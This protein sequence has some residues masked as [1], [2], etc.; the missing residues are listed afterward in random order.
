MTCAE[1]R[2]TMTDST[3]KADEAEEKD[4]LMQSLEKL[5]NDIVSEVFA[6]SGD[7]AK[8]SVVQDDQD[9]PIAD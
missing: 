1:E 4:E 2:D 6:D 8:K 5:V 3:D 9:K 7:E